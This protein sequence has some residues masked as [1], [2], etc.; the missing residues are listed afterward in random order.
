[1]DVIVKKKAPYFGK[2]SNNPFS[3]PYTSDVQQAARRI[4]RC[5]PRVKY[6][7]KSKVVPVV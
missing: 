1:M 6:K 4:Y 5:G 7:G 3:S 2:D